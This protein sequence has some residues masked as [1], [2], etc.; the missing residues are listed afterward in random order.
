MMSQAFLRWYLLVGALGIVS[1][2]LVK[3]DNPT[4]S[5]ETGEAEWALPEFAQKSYSA[6]VP[7]EI[8]EMPWW[9]EARGRPDGVEE[10]PAKV[11]TRKVSWVFRGIIE[12]QGKRFALIANDAQAPLKR[13]QPGDSLP[14]EELLENIDRQNIRFSRPGDAKG[15]DLERKLYE[16]AK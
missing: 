5:A 6:A 4:P 14:G 2:L 16:P 11:L 9:K 15:Q 13:Y 12:V 10:D 7:R 3:S 8:S 1:G